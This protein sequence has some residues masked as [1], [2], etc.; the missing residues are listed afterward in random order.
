MK[1]QL[2]SDC[3][4]RFSTPKQVFQSWL[5][6]FFLPM[7]THLLTSEIRHGAWLLTLENG[8]CA[9]ARS[10]EL[11]GELV[12]GTEPVDKRAH[13]GRGKKICSSFFAGSQ[14]CAS[15]ESVSRFG[16]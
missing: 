5:K 4:Q 9:G 3:G 11:G 8:R 14:S 2:F 7:K 12:A 13:H 1:N 10:E 16:S 6:Q 15:V